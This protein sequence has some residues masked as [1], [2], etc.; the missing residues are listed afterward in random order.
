MGTSG[1]LD[2]LR[3]GFML[4]YD[5]RTWEVTGH[6]TY[7]HE[8]WPAEEWRLENGGDALFLEHESEQGDLFRLLR[9]ADITDVTV[10]GEPFLAAVRE[11]DPPNTVTYE[12]D[13]YLLAE[14]D[15]RIRDSPNQ[16]VRSRTNAWLMGVCG[17][18]AEHMDIPPTYARIGFIAAILVSGFFS[19]GGSGCLLIPGYF[20]V[21]ASMS[22]APPS[23]PREGLSHY[24]VY[25]GEDRFVAFECLGEND[26]NVYAG[27]EVE[28]YEFD[29]ILP[30]SSS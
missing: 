25:Q 29:N 17:G 5:M 18:I 4:D 10:E 13:E 26:W 23:P 20:I 15:A 24:W 1:A 22:K 9:P 11:A 3:E 2:Q 27:R 30:R 16:V 6:V 8:G 7:D 21:G 12:G 19:G 28:P 14:E